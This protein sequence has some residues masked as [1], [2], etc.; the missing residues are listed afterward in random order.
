[1][2]SS[3]V[4]ACPTCGVEFALDQIANHPDVQPIGMQFEDT[5]HEFNFYYFNHAC[6]GCGTTFLI[7]VLAFLPLIVEPVP[8]LVRTGLEDCGRHCLDVRDLANC[9]APCRYAPFRRHL[10][11]MRAQ[12]D[13]ARRRKPAA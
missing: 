5:N 1:M 3:P 7:P 11:E 9:G 12:S 6:P 13:A 10:L 2:A 8:D 4:K